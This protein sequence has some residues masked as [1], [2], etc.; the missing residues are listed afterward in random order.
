MNK[1][2]ED[3]RRRRRRRRAASVVA[4]LITA[5]GLAWFF[6]SQATTTIIFLRYA[7]L[8]PNGQTNPGLSDS[9]L[10]RADE[11]VRVIGDVDVVAGVDAIY[12]TRFRSTQET[13]EPLAEKLQLPVRIFDAS[14]VVGICETMLTEHKGKIVLVVTDRTSL[15]LM[16]RELHGS[17]KLPP[18]A[19][20]EH[21]NLY[22]VSIPWFGKVKTLRL[23]YGRPYLP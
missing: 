6:E 4:F 8:E 5:L 9:G 23:K 13:V 12:A 18:M 11:L 10:Q 15:P 3:K 17:K 7:N 14:D 2:L 19:D 16:I 1:G 20:T 22:I 21:D